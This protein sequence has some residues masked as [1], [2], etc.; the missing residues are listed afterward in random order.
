MKELGDHASRLC[1][2]VMFTTYT[3]VL[4]R[5]GGGG[6]AAEAQ[7]ADPAPTPL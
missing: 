1:I 3:G 4:G 7:G 5:V 2:S 6:W